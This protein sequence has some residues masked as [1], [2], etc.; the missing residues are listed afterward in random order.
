M[1]DNKLHDPYQS[2]FRKD[3]STETALNLVLDQI[4]NLLDHVSAVQLVLLDLI[5]AFDTISHDILIILIIAI[6][7]LCLSWLIILMLELFLF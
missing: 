4:F 1:F 6:C 2:A 5:S 7:D 3:H